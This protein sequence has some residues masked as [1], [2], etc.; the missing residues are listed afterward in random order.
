ML[1]L[2]ARQFCHASTALAAKEKCNKKGRDEQAPTDKSVKAQVTGSHGR[3]EL[4]KSRS[5]AD[6]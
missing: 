1:D 5:S 4:E 2:M 6:R 3:S